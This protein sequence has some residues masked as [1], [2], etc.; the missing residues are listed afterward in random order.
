M[1]FSNTGQENTSDF[2]KFLVSLEQHGLRIRQKSLEW[3]SKR[4]GYALGHR[5]DIVICL[6][7]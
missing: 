3:P 2:L 1:Q 6:N 4:T 7:A 5:K